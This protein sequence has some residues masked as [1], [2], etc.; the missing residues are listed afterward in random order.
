MT[1][2][3]A[4]IDADGGSLAAYRAKRAAVIVVSAAYVAF[5]AWLALAVG[6][7]V[8][9]VGANL[10]VSG[11]TSSTSWA[12]PAG[13]GVALAIGA[14]SAVVAGVLAAVRAVA[15][16]RHG[17]ETALA[18]VSALPADG[19]RDQRL[20]NVVEELS[21]ASGQ[22]VPAV[23]VIA[24]DVPNALSASGRPRP[25]LA[26][27]TGLCEV[28]SRAELAAV[29]GHELTHLRY[30]DGVVQL[31]VSVLVGPMEEESRR[32]SRSGRAFVMFIPAFICWALASLLG[33]Y[34]STGQEA[35]TDLNSL[36]LTR[37][38]GALADALDKMRR[39]RGTL[40]DGEAT[41][42]QLLTVPPAEGDRE[43]GRRI[44]ALRE[45]TA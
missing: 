18:S 4:R 12:E 5:W 20:L 36:E 2:W 28:L 41:V 38:P 8:I 29:V 26:V 40:G 27:T 43:L 13:T 30:H 44:S 22:T 15:V 19:T 32:L 35:L 7:S 24:S 1:D 14:L 10:L 42:A 3:L 39:A 17:T 9:F 6:F 23:Y 31:F 25:C 34:A 45:M 16:W 11:S 21:L 37:D 33:H